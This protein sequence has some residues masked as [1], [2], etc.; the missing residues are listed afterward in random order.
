MPAVRAGEL[1]EHLCKHHLC[2]PEPWDQ[3][4]PGFGEGRQ[5]LAAL[6]VILVQKQR[7]RVPEAL[8]AWLERWPAVERALQDL[9]RV[10]MRRMLGLSISRRLRLGRA[11]FLHWIVCRLALAHLDPSKYGQPTHPQVP[12]PQRHEFSDALL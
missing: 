11:P 3:A 7:E 6:L 8:R 4:L 1:F 5:L 12:E 2:A 9:P 10:L